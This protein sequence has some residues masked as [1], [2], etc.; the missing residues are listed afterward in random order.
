MAK[1]QTLFEISSRKPPFDPPRTGITGVKNI[2]IWFHSPLLP[3][4]AHQPLH[5]L[6]WIA[7]KEV[8]EEDIG[9]S[10]RAWAARSGESRTG[11]K[12]IRHSSTG[13]HGYSKAVLQLLIPRSLLRGAS[14][15]TPEGSFWQVRTSRACG[16]NSCRFIGQQTSSFTIHS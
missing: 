9:A 6:P 7:W 3:T 15:G 13:A 4:R 12:A 11:G 16:R 1:F 10:D 5:C 14:L 2:S 8:T